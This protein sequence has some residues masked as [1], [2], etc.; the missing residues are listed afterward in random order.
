MNRP[1]LRAHPD[2]VVP[3]NPT[4]HVLG[5]EHAA[6]VVVEYGDFECPTCKQAAPAVKMLLQR[7]R[8]R[9]QFVFRHFPL[10]ALHPHA[11]QAAQAAESAAGQGKFWLMHDLLFANQEH[12]RLKHLRD[13][14][15]QLGLDM[16]RFDAEMR[17]EIYL[18]RIREHIDGGRRSHLKS[19]PGFFV[20]GVIVDVSFGLHAVVDATAAAFETKRE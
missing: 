6:A 20:N 9:V 11:L 18:Q 4:D 8:E 14:A 2:L 1:N 16:A 13:Y 12:L 19:T 7:F 15:S 17:D 3:V 10:E 5:S